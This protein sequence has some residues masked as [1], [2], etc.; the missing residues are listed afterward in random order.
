MNRSRLVVSLLGGTLV[1]LASASAMGPTAW[2]TAPR[3]TLEARTTQESVDGVPVSA[4]VLHGSD[5]RIRLDAVGGWT[6][7]AAC[8][9]H[10]S[11]VLAHEN[12]PD[13][14][15]AFSLFAADELLPDLSSASWEGYIDA[16]VAT[17]ADRLARVVAGGNIET[18]GRLFVFGRPYREIT[19]TTRTGEEGRLGARREVFVFLG[20]KLLV[21]SLGGESAA[22]ERLSRGFELFLA[23]LEILP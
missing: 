8:P 20:E 17:H 10:G 18:E 21:I 16:I 11:I 1:A 19:Y 6:R 7:T 5:I 22:V 14:A 9:P 13:V 2:P 12:V 23:R 4:T 3:P 15:L